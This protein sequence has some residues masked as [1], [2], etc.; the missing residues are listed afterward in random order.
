VARAAVDSATSSQVISITG[1]GS[2]SQIERWYVMFADNSTRTGA[3][4]VEVSEGK[5]DKVYPSEKKNSAGR[6]FQPDQV[7]V[8]VE[9]ALETAKTYARLNAIKYDGVRVLLSR[10]EGA[11]PAFWKVELRRDGDPVGSVY[12]K[13]IDGSFSR[14]EPLSGRSAKK[15]KTK[16]FDDELEEAF[17]EVGGELEDFFTGKRTIDR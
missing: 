16:D 12:T 14:Y 17:G 4:V 15:K 6:T 9:K 13:A 2:P 7:N 10:P 1:K 8:P 3:R 5:I 11:K